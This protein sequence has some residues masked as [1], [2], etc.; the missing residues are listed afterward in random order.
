MKTFGATIHIL[1]GKAEL[2]SGGVDPFF[3][4]SWYYTSFV[5]KKMNNYQE[6]NFL[7]LIIYLA[8]ILDR[9]LNAFSVH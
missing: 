6:S 5:E 1:E 3:Q 2:G 7:C 8:D 4:A 9:I